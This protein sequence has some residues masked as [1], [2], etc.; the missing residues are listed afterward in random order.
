MKKDL[1]FSIAIKYREDGDWKGDIQQIN[2]DKVKFASSIEML[3][4]LE[5]LINEK[6]SKEE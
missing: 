6:Q 5:K 2:D 3:Q 1:I 4:I